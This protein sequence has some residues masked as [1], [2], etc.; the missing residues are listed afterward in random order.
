MIELA[1]VFRRHGPEYRQKYEG[2]IPRRHLKAMDAIEQCR[3]RALGG[4]VYRCKNCG[5]KEYSYHSCKNRSCPKCQNEEASRWLENQRELLLPVPYYLVTFTLPEELRAPARSNQK[6]IYG[7]MFR[8]S[9]HALKELAGDRR[10]LEG[11]IGMVGV[12]QTWSRD[13]TYHPHIHYLIPGGALSLD[14]SAWIGTQYKDWLVPVRALSKLFRG[15]LKSML[16]KAGFTD[17]IPRRVWKKKWCVHC[18]AVGTGEQALKYLAPYIRRIAITNRRIKHLHK[19]RVTFMTG[20]ND[21]GHRERK[22][23]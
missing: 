20:K 22:V 1:E 21:I 6:Q 7:M 10:H 2:R 23:P 3:T 4:H 18:K 17:K 19:D 5:E 9:A 15:K 8:A 14:G 13:M 12:L 11:S 16:C